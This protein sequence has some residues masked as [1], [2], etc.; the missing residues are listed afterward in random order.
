MT[1]DYLEATSNKDEITNDS[2]IG[3]MVDLGGSTGD[4]DIFIGS[5]TSQNDVLDARVAHDLEFAEVAGGQISVK[6]GTDVN[7]HLSDVDYIMVRDRAQGEETTQADINAYDTT[8]GNLEDARD[9][10]QEAL[11]NHNAQQVVLDGIASDKASAAATAASESTTAAD[12]ASAHAAGKASLVVARDD[13]QDALDDHDA[14][15]VVL[16]GIA[17]DKASAAATATSEINRCCR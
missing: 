7:A 3:V 12:N 9:N 5:D 17:S 8:K 16:D 10:A 2:D 14:Q 1:I 11:D 4:A 13:A 15:Q 6:S